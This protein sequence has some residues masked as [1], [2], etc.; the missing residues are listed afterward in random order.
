MKCR[1]EI[2][3][4]LCVLLYLFLPVYGCTTN[5]II[6]EFAAHNVVIYFVRCFLKGLLNLTP[7][8]TCWFYDMAT[9]FGLEIQK[10]VFGCLL[11]KKY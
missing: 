11:K 1:I 7:E 3:V 5:R 9:E 8:T 6:K 4:I 2:C 10:L